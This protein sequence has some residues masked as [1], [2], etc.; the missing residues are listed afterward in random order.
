M[1]FL[2]IARDGG[3][4]AALERRLAARPAHIARGDAQAATGEQVFGAAILGGDGA[5][6][7][8][9]MVVEAESREALGRWLAAEPYVTGGVWQRVE[10]HPCAVGPSFVARGRG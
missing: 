10:I 5:M 7:G 8:S 3:D 4:A 9:I 2:I 1:H 6:A